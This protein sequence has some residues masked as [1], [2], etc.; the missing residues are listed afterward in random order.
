MTLIHASSYS[1]THSSVGIT[2]YGPHWNVFPLTCTSCS[3]RK[4]TKTITKS[5]THRLLNIINA[6]GFS[7]KGHLKKGPTYVCHH[8]ACINVAWVLREVYCLE[9]C[10]QRWSSWQH[11][12]LSLTRR[13]R[14]TPYMQNV[15]ATL[16]H[17]SDLLVHVLFAL[18]GFD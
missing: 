17:C 16:P 10:L 9:F 12:T 13:A 1:R 15:S 11:M 2:I 3:A 4:K 6:K 5:L 18:I 8:Y 7:Q 14:V